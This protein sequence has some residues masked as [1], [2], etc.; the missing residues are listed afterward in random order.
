MDFRDRF[1][2]SMSIGANFRRTGLSESVCPVCLGEVGSSIGFRR[3]L[4]V[5]VSRGMGAK[6]RPLGLVEAAGSGFL[7]LVIVVSMG[8]GENLDFGFVTGSSGLRLLLV[9]VSM[10]CGE[11]LDFGF[12]ED[13][14]AAAFR[15]LVEVVSIG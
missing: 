10:G 14:S 3:L 11:N 5:V 4:L 2:V 7:L 15:L 6:R 12:G 8:W 1:E 9:V 13:S